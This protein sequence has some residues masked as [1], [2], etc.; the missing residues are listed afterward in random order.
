ML[1]K[2]CCH[3]AL[4]LLVPSLCFSLPP[5]LCETLFLR[6]CVGHPCSLSTR[7]TLFML[8]QS[9][10]LFPSLSHAG[11]HACSLC[12]RLY[13]SLS[14]SRALSFPYPLALLCVRSLAPSLPRSL[15]SSCVPCWFLITKT[16]CATLR[17]YLRLSHPYILQFPP[18][19]LQE[20]GS[21]FMATSVESSSN[22]TYKVVGK[23]QRL[24]VAGASNAQEHTRQRKSMAD[25]VDDSTNSISP[26]TAA[27]SAT[28][29]CQDLGT[30]LLKDWQ[31]PPNIKS[32]PAKLIDYFLWSNKN[33]INQLVSQRYGGD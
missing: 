30:K 4:C 31:F 9:L 10:A 24:I 23:I 3:S 19:S 20:V 22:S 15:D 27:D 12:V 29:A 1:H 8:H 28:A 33:N 25:D 6:D 16:L 5:A 13:L 21:H 7:H 2:F 17:V 26:Q 18:A 11:M 32:V 14:V